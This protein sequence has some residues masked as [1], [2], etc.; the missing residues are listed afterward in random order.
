MVDL[1]GN[2]SSGASKVGHLVLYGAHGFA[3]DV[4][5]SVYDALFSVANVAMTME[6]NLNMNNKNLINTNRLIADEITASS[7]STKQIQGTLT[8]PDLV[9]SKITGTAPAITNTHFQQCH[10]AFSSF[11]A[12]G[13][14]SSNV[15][16]NFNFSGS[17]TYLNPLRV[18]IK[19]LYISKHLIIPNPVSITLTTPFGRDKKFNSYNPRNDTFD[20][21]SN[22]F[23]LMGLTLQASAVNGTHP[24][25]TLSALLL[26]YIIV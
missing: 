19:K 2:V 22:E 5:T 21:N 25:S 13:K 16:K 20:G 10:C 18:Y 23:H 1:H 17:E 15:T 8:V 24:N 26:G 4:P 7:I 12:P 3:P 11:M 6:T 9:V 14:N